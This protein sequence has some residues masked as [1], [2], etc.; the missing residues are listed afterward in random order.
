MA[1]GAFLAL[2][3]YHKQEKVFILL[4]DWENKKLRQVG[5]ERV[6]F[7]VTLIIM[8]AQVFLLVRWNNLSSPAPACCTGG[9]PDL[10]QICGTLWGSAGGREIFLGGS[11][12]ALV[13]VLAQAST[14]VLG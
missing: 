10:E 12:V 9:S 3:N 6:E 11:P 8:S 7:N 4:W 5:E 13:E 14:S 1:S 2:R